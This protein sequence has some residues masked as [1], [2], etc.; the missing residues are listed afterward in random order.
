MRNGQAIADAL[1]GE[2]D[3]KGWKFCCP[4]HDDHKPSASIR[5]DGLVTCWV[6][7]PERRRELCAK[8][9]ELGFKDNDPRPVDRAAGRAAVAAAQRTAQEFWDK[10]GHLGGDPDFF[11]APYL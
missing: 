6:C 7:G 10:I 8:L 3:S 1:G 2:P 5:F 9:D 4:I 11:I